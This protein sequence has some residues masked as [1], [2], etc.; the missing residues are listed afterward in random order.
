MVTVADYYLHF[1][2]T[3]TTSFVDEI[4]DY[5][6]GAREEGSMT[7]QE[8]ESL[9]I[10]KALVKALA[11]IEKYFGDP[12]DVV[13]D[14]RVYSNSLPAVKEAVDALGRHY[15]EGETT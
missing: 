12:I 11:R 8:R 4:A 2:T 9:A 14:A 7:K 6:I 3:R 1:L 5:S 13:E 15:S 10:A